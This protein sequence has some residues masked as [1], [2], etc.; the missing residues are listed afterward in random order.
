MFSFHKCAGAM[1]LV[2][3]SIAKI[4]FFSQTRAMD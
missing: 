1:R 3:N 2:Y 4:H